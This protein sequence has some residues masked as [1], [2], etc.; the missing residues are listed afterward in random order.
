[1]F[2]L[3]IWIGAPMDHKENI[4]KNEVCRRNKVGGKITTRPDK[5]KREVISLRLNL[6]IQ[7]S[8]VT[9]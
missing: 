4:H 8:R 2:V 6:S 5:K 7:I 1:M 9:R 3:K